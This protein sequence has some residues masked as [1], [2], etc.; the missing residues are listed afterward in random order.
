MPFLRQVVALERQDN[1]R[2]AVSGLKSHREKPET[3]PGPVLQLTDF[4]QCTFKHCWRA[5]CVC[6]CVLE[7]GEGGSNFE[8]VKN[9]FN[10]ENQ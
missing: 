2:Q 6:V 9:V 3:G 1:R 7:E 5:L 10:K 8:N 4:W